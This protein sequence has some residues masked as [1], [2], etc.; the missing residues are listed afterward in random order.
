MLRNIGNWASEASPTLGC[1]IEISCD[2]Y[3]CMSVFL[4]KPIQKR[5]MPKCV[6]GIMWPKHAHA[7]S[8][9]WAVTTETPV[10][11]ILTIH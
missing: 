1:S 2:I 9:I 10:L 5:R 8:Q 7:Q 11:F 4:G 6:G 3:V